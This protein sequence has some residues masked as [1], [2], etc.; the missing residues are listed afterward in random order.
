MKR[1]AFSLLLLSTALF[2]CAFLDS[3]APKDT[4]AQTDDV[5]DPDG[6]DAETAP[7]DP[8]QLA[9]EQG[10]ERSGCYQVALSFTFDEC[11]GLLGNPTFATTAQIWI[12]IDYG[13]MLHVTE[14]SG[15]SYILPATSGTTYSTRLDAM[16]GPSYR[17]TYGIQLLTG[18]RLTGWL[19]QGSPCVREGSLEGQR[20]AP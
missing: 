18:N 19:S 5:V 9:V 4:T 7:T 1:I 6:V 2:Q 17:G 20:F 11:G 10:G 14:Q 13:N 3:C 12:L 15:V 16:I 8:C